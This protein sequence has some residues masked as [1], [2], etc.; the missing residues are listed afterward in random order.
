[1]SFPKH[2]HSEMSEAVAINPS[3]LVACIDVEILIDLDGCARAQN[4]EKRK[5]SLGSELSDN[6]ILTVPI[7]QL[8]TVPAKHEVMNLKG[9]LT[10]ASP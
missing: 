6:P 10:A 7:Q 3:D 5:S 2:P 1:M 4:F 8:L 9:T